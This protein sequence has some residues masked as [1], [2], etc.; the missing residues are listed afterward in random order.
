MQ[1]LPYIHSSRNDHIL[2]SSNIN[3]IIQNRFC[4]HFSWQ[5]QTML[6]CALQILTYITGLSYAAVLYT[7]VINAVF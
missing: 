2:I 6:L 7:S 4:S 3:W 1:Q 5:W